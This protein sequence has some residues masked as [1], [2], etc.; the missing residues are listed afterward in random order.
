MSDP[1]VNVMASRFIPTS[2][3]WWMLFV[4]GPIVYGAG[5]WVI[6]LLAPR[7]GWAA[8]Y[9]GPWNLT[10]LILVAVGTTG[11][12]WS[13]ALHSAQ[14]PEG[15]EMKPAQRYLLTRGPYAFTRH[16]TYLSILTLLF[17]W[18]VFYGSVAVFIAFVAG[19]VFFN[20]AARGEE[21]ALEA[22]LGE[23]YLAYKNKVP[24]WFGK[25]R[26]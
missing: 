4:A 1:R 7:Y 11:L 2:T 9:P 14:S 6:S 8:G 22:R 10:G 3:L 20:V 26:P 13:V 16:P 17:G 15:V 18:V 5:P 21:R 23:A 25:T 12:I 19:C 24:R